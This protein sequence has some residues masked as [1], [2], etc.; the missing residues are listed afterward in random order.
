MTGEV[1]FAN[2]LRKLRPYYNTR[3]S[4]VKGR[5]LGK[6]LVDVLTKEFRLYPREHYV[7]EINKNHFK[8]IRD[9]IPL[10]PTEVFESAIK[11]K[12]IIETIS[13]K[14]EPPVRQWCNE[15]EEAEDN[16]NRIAGFDIV[17][18]DADILVINKPNGIPIHPTGQFYQ[19]TITEILK[20]HDKPVLP[21]YRLDKVTSGLLIMAKNKIAAGKV[22][23]KIRAR[24]MSKLYLARVQGKFPNV[25]ERSMIINNTINDA[26]IMF[27]DSTIVTTVDSH[28]YTIEPKKQF[29]AGLSMSREAITLF[30]PLSYL[31]KENQSVV[32]CKPLTGRTHQI[33]IHLARLGFPIVNDS[34][35]NEAKATYPERLKFMLDYGNWES[36][37]LSTEHLS[38]KFAEFV[39]EVREAHDLKSAGKLNKFRCG[40]CGCWE[41]D[42]PPVED[43]VLWLHAWKY[44]DSEG[45]FS[46][47][48][49]LPLWACA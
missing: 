10:K 39:A 5:W 34:M 42:D 3:T 8:I 41:M 13:H 21:C 24:D 4:F 26:S 1:Y 15:Q 29:P 27:D 22:Q 19:N 16:K 28:V 17:H 14:H 45:T 49:K 6:P 32:V 43:L 40:E 18:E 9:D 25:P 38:K 33:R 2:G 46:F 36:S 31:P 30:Y 35:Y 12:D 20:S 44:S 11:N 47:E 37:G 23:S 7:S 48:T